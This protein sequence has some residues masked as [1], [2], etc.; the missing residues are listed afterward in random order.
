MDMLGL[1]E[2]VKG[3]A[4]AH[5]VR[6]YGLMLRRDDDSVLRWV[7]RESEGD[8][9]RPA[10]RVMWRDGVQKNAETMG[11]IWSTHTKRTKPDK[12]LITTTTT[13]YEEN[14]F[15]TMGY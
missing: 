14:S 4:K 9:R 5:G 2:T 10:R 1:K 15:L 11:Y 3:L 7:A 12:N 8:Q 6:W 13:T